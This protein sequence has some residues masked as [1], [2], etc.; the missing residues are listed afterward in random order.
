MVNRVNR[1]GTASGKIQI[2]KAKSYEGYGNVISFSFVTKIVKVCSLSLYIYIHRNSGIPMAPY[3]SRGG[4]TGTIFKAVKIAFTTCSEN[5]AD[6]IQFTPKYFYKP[7]S[8][9]FYFIYFF[10]S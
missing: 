6:S 8:S 5:A 10:N 4:E 7:T 3:V 1:V 2:P 9:L